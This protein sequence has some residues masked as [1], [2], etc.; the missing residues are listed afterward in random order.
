MKK[1]TAFPITLLISILIFSCTLQ[2]KKKEKAANPENEL[3]IVDET[4]CIDKNLPKIEFSVE[5]P[6]HMKFLPA[7]PS[8]FPNQN[9]AIMGKY[10]NASTILEAIQI[11]ALYATDSSKKKIDKQKTLR[12][13]LKGYRNFFASFTGETGVFKVNGK[14]YAMMRGKVEGRFYGTNAGTLTGKYL[15][16]SV[17]VMGNEETSKGI[18]LTMMADQERTEIKTYD[19]F[20]TKGD[21]GEIWQTLEF[22]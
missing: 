6:K 3:F 15:I 18:V 16:Q 11:E 19:D 22:Y 4:F 13:I 8:E 2:P 17:I 14:E 5:Y 1:N 7:K 20:V 10:R 21:L 12:Y 9:Y